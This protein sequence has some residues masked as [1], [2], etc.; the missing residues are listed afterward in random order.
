MRTVRKVLTLI[1]ALVMVLTMAGCS[2]TADDEN[3]T[4]ITDN[5]ADNNT[6]DNNTVDNNTADNRVTDGNSSDQG[7][8]TLMNFIGCWTCNS[9]DINITLVID[10]AYNWQACNHDEI[11]CTGFTQVE[12]GWVYLYTS[13]GTYYCSLKYTDKAV[14]DEYGSVYTFDGPVEEYIPSGMVDV[15]AAPAAEEYTLLLG[16]YYDSENEGYYI[17]ITEGLNYEM[18]GFDEDT[19]ALIDCGYLEKIDDSGNYTVHP[20]MYEGED[21]YEIFEFDTGVL[22]WCGTMYYLS[23]D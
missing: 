3:N 2:K 5:T 21:T 11:F 4:I 13:D 8:F 20:T 6:A 18:Y 23:E 7:N 22:S 16:K 9:E 12:Y 1:L 19:P 15:S 17:E 10:S 14:E